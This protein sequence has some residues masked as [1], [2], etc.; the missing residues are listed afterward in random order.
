MALEE[1]TTAPEMQQAGNHQHTEPTHINAV[2]GVG[3]PLTE[4]FPAAEATA[5]NGSSHRT[6]DEKDGST[7]TPPWAAKG[8][9]LRV[10]KGLVFS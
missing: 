3:D 1:G 9:A 7:R 8:Q 2:I 5:A 10:W 6:T 4:R